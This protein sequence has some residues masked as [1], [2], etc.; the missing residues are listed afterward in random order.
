MILREVNLEKLGQHLKKGQIFI[1]FCHVIP[2]NCN[3]QKMSFIWPNLNILRST[4]LQTSLFL[5]IK[6][7]FLTRRMGTAARIP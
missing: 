6:Q 3:C 7:V 1:E 4:F 2:R 5:C